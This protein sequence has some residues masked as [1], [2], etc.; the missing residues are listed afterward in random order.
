MDGYRNR[1]SGPNKLFRIAAAL[2]ADGKTVVVVKLVAP[3]ENSAEIF[4]ALWEPV[5]AVST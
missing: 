2:L 5:S 1:Q 3:V 4:E